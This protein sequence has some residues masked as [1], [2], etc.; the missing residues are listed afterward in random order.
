MG[1][2]PSER[3]PISPYLTYDVK[4]KTPEPCIQIGQRTYKLG[5]RITSEDG[6]DVKSIGGAVTGIAQK[7]S[8]NF[9][10]KI[11]VWRTL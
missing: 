4:S 6:H 7:A 1:V 10:P 3:R 9:P 2:M 11:A 8:D 5:S